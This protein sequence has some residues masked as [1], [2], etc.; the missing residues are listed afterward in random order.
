MAGGSRRSVGRLRRY[1]RRLRPHAAGLAGAGGLLALSGL[2]P[3]LAVVLLERALAATLRGAARPAGLWAAAFAVVILLSGAVRLLRTAWTKHIGWRV[4][5]E[6]RCALFARLVEGVGPAGTGRRL[7]ALLGEVD[8]VQYGV[9]ALVGVLRDPLTL[10]GLVAAAAWMAPGLIGWAVVLVPV[11]AVVGALGGRWAERTARRWRERRAALAG[12]GQEQLAGAAAL[13][14]AGASAT[15][16]ERFERLNQADRAAR[17]RREVVGVVPGVATE[18]AVAS[19][20]AVLLAVGAVQVADGRLDGAGL[21]GFIV[22]LGL[23]ARP[24]GRLSEVWGL[25]LRALASLET[26]DATL[27]APPRLPE[28][29]V[30]V[31]LPQGPL[32]VELRGASVDHGRGPVLSSL[33]CEVPAG[34]SLALVAPT[35]AGKTTLLRLVG[36]DLDVDG[37]SVLLGGVDVRDLRLGELRAAVAMVSQTPALFARSIRDNVALGRD[38]DDAAV[39]RALDAASADFVRALPLGLDT[40]LGERGRAVSGGEGQR[41]ALA[42]A[43]AGDPRVLLLDEPTSHV[44]AATRDAILRALVAL[45]GRVTLVVATHDPDVAAA[46]DRVLHLDAV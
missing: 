11:V 8:E 40:Q 30:P 37:G 17:W 32:S 39:L 35:G 18:A 38:L 28:P 31:P 43:L 25:L 33:S 23:A 1:G 29:G 3:G 44:D 46:V 6:L 14:S 27:S 7:V 22:A 26:V 20:V 4:A 5:A 19:C 42:R 13:R 12:L 34:G 36:R 10:V 2:L 45:R 24:L 9:S 41:I 15:E 21:V 16:A